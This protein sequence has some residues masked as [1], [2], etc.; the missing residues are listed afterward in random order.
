MKRFVLVLLVVL[1]LA[2]AALAQ[3]SFLANLSGANEVPPADPDGTG[4]ALITITGTTVTYS[5]TV[6]NIAAPTAQHI[7]SGVAGVNGPIVVNLPGV[8]VG[9]GDGP[10]T[11][12]GATTS[13]PATIAAIVANPA[14]FYVNVH[15]APFPGGAVRGQL[16]AFTGTIPT[17]STWGLI[18]LGAMLALAG[19]VVARRA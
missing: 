14:A 5:I 15:N 6:D 12:N 17:A 11:L 18:A 16:A 3:Q 7:H 19:L 9:A 10:W 13:D 4:T 2:P 8:W 1:A